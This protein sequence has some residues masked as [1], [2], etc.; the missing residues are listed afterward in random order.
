MKDDMMALALSV[1]DAYIKEY[2]PELTD[3]VLYQVVKT[4]IPKLGNPELLEAEINQLTDQIVEQFKAQGY[5][6]LPPSPDV[7]AIAAQVATEVDQF[8]QERSSQVVATDVTKPK[9]LGDLEVGSTFETRPN[10]PAS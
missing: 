4:I 3:S 10:L 1:L 2:H 7:K 9:L 8:L 6:E 5:R